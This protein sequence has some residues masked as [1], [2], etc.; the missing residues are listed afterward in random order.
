MFSV[1]LWLRGVNRLEEAWFIG[2]N[3]R[4][5]VIRVPAVGPFSD[6]GWGVSA[7]VVL[8]LFGST[9]AVEKRRDCCRKS[10]K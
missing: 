2:V 9:I 1:L 4:L 8:A 3:R 10:F 6:K 5:L 7:L